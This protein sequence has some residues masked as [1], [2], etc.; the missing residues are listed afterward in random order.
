M[1]DDLTMSDS[2]NRVPWPP[3]LYALAA[4]AAVLAHWTFPLPW[5]QGATAFAVMMVGIFLW[6]AAFS[7]DLTAAMLFRKSRTTILPHRGATTLVKNGPY[8]YS[9]NPIYVA[10]TLWLAGGG[11]VFGIG[12]LILAALAAAM[13]THQLAVLREERHLAAK[14]GN[15]WAQYAAR[16]PRWLGFTSSARGPPL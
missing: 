14:F 9:R 12:W 6:A 5:P 4:I 11:L 3:V 8:R 10:H 15:D 2:P 7:L 1:I 16:V 13:A